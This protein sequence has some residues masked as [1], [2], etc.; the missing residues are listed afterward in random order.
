MIF[1]YTI[2]AW[3]LP[4]EGHPGNHSALLSAEQWRALG[5]RPG[6]RRRR[7]V[8]A[9][10]RGS[11]EAELCRAA[12]ARLRREPDCRPSRR[13][14][15]PA[16]SVC[17]IAARVDSAGVRALFARPRARGARGCAA[18]RDRQ[19]R[20]GVIDE[21]RRL[22]QPRRHVAHGRAARLVR[23]RHRHAACTGASRSRASTSSSA[24]PRSTSSGLL[25]ELG[26]TWSRD[27]QPLLPIGTLY[28][29]F[30]EPCARAVVVRDLRRRPVDPGRHAVRRDPGARGRR[31]PVDHHAVDR[32]RAAAVHRLGAG[33]RPGPGVGA[34][35]ARSDGSGAPDGCSAYFR[36]CTRP[37][38][39]ALA[40]VPDD[41]SRVGA[42]RRP[43]ARRRLPHAARGGAPGG[44]A[45][46]DGR[47]HARGSG[48]GRR[49]WSATAS[50]GDVV[51]LTSA[52][53]VFRALQ[54]R[55][56]LG[57]RR[58]RD[59]RRAAARASGRPRS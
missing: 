24:S 26:L 17:R 40:G 45:G 54:A 16:T 56:G 20:C 28:D 27:G 36:L 29:P 2:K 7:P 15:P 18:C 22:D 50:A 35:V 48:R 42:R 11:P 31:A 38:D 55:Q 44:D 21:P 1:A 4:T 57:R 5:R 25:A 30:V 9:L 19:P 8:G 34:A 53:L 43:G 51:C 32:A 12:A 37:I 41:P 52:D 47:G 39:Q 59:P 49:A 58:G 6:R 14:R 3:R 33:L 23:R 10:P 13:R 46:R